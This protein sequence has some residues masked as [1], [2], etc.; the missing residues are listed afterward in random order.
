MLKRSAAASETPLSPVSD[1]RRQSCKQARL[2]NLSL[3][4]FLLLLAVAVGWRIFKLFSSEHQLS[5][6]RYHQ[7]GQEAIHWSWQT[8]TC[9]LEYKRHQWKDIQAGKKKPYLFGGQQEPKCRNCHVDALWSHFCQ[10]RSFVSPTLSMRMLSQ[11]AAAAAA[12]SALS[13]LLH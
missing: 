7:L 13:Q 1:R 12:H 3:K 10:F 11:H 8:P 5:P 9:P 4:S 6:W 2:R